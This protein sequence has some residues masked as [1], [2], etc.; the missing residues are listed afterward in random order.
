M[1]VL[2]NLVMIGSQRN[3]DKQAYFILETT[4]ND[5]PHMHK[6]LHVIK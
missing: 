1:E 3:Y 6:I 2:Q 5:K 4:L